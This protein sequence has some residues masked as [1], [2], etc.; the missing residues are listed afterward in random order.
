MLHDLPPS[1]TLEPDRQRAI[2][3]GRFMAESALYKQDH[4]LVRAET[5]DAILDTVLEFNLVPISNYQ[6]GV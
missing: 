1:T 6:A 2:L 5:I 3:K 4:S